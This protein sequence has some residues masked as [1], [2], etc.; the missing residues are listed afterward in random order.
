MAVN[1]VGGSSGFDIEQLKG[2]QVK[3]NNLEQAKSSSEPNILKDQLESRLKSRQPANEPP[4][5]SVARTTWGS[6]T[7]SAR[8]LKSGS[9]GATS[10]T[11]SAERLSRVNSV[12]NTATPAAP[13]KR[14]V[15]FT[16]DAGKHDLTN[17]QLKGSFNKTTG[18]YDPQWGN[19]DTVA[20]KSLG[21]GKWSATIELLDD[22]QA[23]NWEWGVVADGPAGKAQW[24]VMGEGNLKFNLNENTKQVNYAPTTYHE[25]GSQKVGKNDI[26]FKFW[27]PNAQHVSV[28]VFDENGR[29]KMVPMK[30]DAEGNWSANVRGGWKSMEGKAYVYQVIDSEGKT[31]ERAD[32]YAFVMQGEQ[33]GIG[34]TYVNSKTG[35]QTNQFFI[36]GDVYQKYK[37]QIEGS[38]PA[39]SMAAREKAYAESRTD[40]LRSMMRLKQIAPC[41]S[42]KMRMVVSSRKT[43]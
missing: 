40:V 32:P 13:I 6:I 31:V 18:Q 37:S 11:T 29:T 38:D 28:K 27:S 43:S 22:G 20:M 7:P 2:D 26:S 16:F 35:E 3:G 15:T 19:G 30:K 9:A 21:N 14:S 23:K 25:M 34:R 42:S 24:A 36:D 8:S 4:V 39:L 33:R 12:T 10:A 1:R 17:L 5:D 41:W